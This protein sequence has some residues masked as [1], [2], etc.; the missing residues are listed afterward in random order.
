MKSIFTVRN[1]GLFAGAF[2][3]IGAGFIFGIQATLWSDSG[4]EWNLQLLINMAMCVSNI[5]MGIL[6]HTVNNKG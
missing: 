5:G 6:C 2:N 4:F 3:F 1:L